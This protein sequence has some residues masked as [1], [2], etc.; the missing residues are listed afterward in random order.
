M[1]FEA[2]LAKHPELLDRSLL[3]RWYRPERL[4]SPAARRSFLLPDPIPH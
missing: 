1:T 3:Q 4:N 2:W